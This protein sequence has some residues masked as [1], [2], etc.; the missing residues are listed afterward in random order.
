MIIQQRHFP[1][2]PSVSRETFCQYQRLKGLTARSASTKEYWVSAA[3]KLGLVDTSKGVFFKQSNHI[4][5]MGAPLPPQAGGIPQDVS[6]TAASQQPSQQV[7]LVRLVEPSDKIFATE[8]SYF[9]MEQMTTCVFTEAD[10]LGKRKCHTVG[11]AGMACKHCVGGNG[12]GRFFPLTL[13]TFSDVSK[14]IHVLRNHLIKCTKAPR[15]MAETVTMLYKQHKNEK[16]SVYWT[17]LRVVRVVLM[18]VV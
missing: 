15:D 18:F 2:C 17:L 13:K 12:S 9:V 1:V 8:Y 7:P 4:D 11:F 3:R 14:S 10:R 16:V 6:T 5:E